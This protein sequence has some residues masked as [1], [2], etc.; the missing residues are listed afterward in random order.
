VEYIHKTSGERPRQGHRAIGVRD[1]RPEN[2]RPR[3]AGSAGAAAYEEQVFELGVALL[4]QDDGLS[5]AQTAFFVRQIRAELTQQ[6]RRIIGRSR[7]LCVRYLLS[8]KAGLPPR[9]S[10][11]NESHG[12]QSVDTG[13]YIVFRLAEIAEAWPPRSRTTDDW[14]GKTPAPLIVGPRFCHGAEAMLREVR[15]MAEAAH[16]ETRRVVEIS[17]LATLVASYLKTAPPARRG[18]R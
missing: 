1:P 2:G 12:P 9:L 17:V 3:G 15:W 18:N 5:Q 4:L 14:Q 16:P 7:T 11:A 8:N 10:S 6:Y 13:V